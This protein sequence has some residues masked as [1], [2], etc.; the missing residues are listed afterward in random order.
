MLLAT[1]APAK[2]TSTHSVPAAQ[3]EM[4]LYVPPPLPVCGEVQLLS[5]KH[6]D[7][8]LQQ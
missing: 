4:E 8:R 1:Q 3:S 5:K 6:R 2:P 7:W